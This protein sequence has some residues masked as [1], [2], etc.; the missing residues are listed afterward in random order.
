MA[1]A[2]YDPRDLANMFKT[3]EQQGGGSS[4]GWFSSHPSPSDRYARI[5]QEAQY[6]RVSNPVR[7]SREFAANS[8]AFAGYGP[9]AV[10]AGDCARRQRYPTGE[11]YR[12]LSHTIRRAVALS[13]P[14][15]RY[16]NYSDIGR[17]G[18]RER[19]KQLAP[20]GDSNSVWFA[21]EGAYGQV[22]NQVVYT[23]GVNFG[24]AQTQSRDSATG[25][26]GIPE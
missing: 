26:P 7:D 19:A 13:Y 18:A 15:T 5:N 21:P 2:G 1:G 14:S 17:R 12:K 4:G 25:D 6:L 10:N 8:G 9:R 24:V 20:A 23:H 3:I 16:Q 11:N 22:Q